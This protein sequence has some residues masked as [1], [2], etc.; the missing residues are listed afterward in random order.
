MHCFNKGQ[1][2]LW[3]KLNLPGFRQSGP[4]P[5]T[6]G[7]TAPNGLKRAQLLQRSAG[8]MFHLWAEVKIVPI[9]T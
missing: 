5:Y 9:N 3:T 4:I 7:S 2:P 1:W 6:R 8:K